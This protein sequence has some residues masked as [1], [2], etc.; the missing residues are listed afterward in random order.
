MH[1][2]KRVLRSPRPNV[3]AKKVDAET[4]GSDK[5]RESSIDLSA[6][7]ERQFLPDAVFSPALRLT[8][9]DAL[10]SLVSEA[11]QVLNNHKAQVRFSDYLSYSHASHP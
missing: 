3:P 11:L 5:E 6:A 4:H 2:N 9:Q 8:I 1:K 10:S 7:F